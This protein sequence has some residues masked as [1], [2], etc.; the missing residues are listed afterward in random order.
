M[1]NSPSTI[2]H[3][4]AKAVPGAPCDGGMP[5]SIEWLATAQ[6][7][8]GYRVVVVAQGGHAT[9]T[10][11]HYRLDRL[12]GTPLKEAIEASASGQT[13]IHFHATDPETDRATGEDL[14]C[15]GVPFVVTVRGNHRTGAL[16]LANRVYLSAN[17]A[18][19]HGHSVFVY[20]G[21]PVDEYPLGPGKGGYALFLGKVSRRKKGAD[22]A[23]RVAR[24]GQPVVLAGGWHLKYPATWLPFVRSLKVAG[25]VGGE[26]KLHLLQHADALLFP[27][28]WDEPFGLVLIESL[29]VGTPVVA[30]QRG[31]VA[32]LVED[33]ISGIISEPEPEALEQ[34]I[35]K[36][37]TLDRGACRQRVIDHFRIERVAQDYDELYRHALAG[38]RW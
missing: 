4:A 21:L 11:E 3:L 17:H 34:A 2:I 20:N 9:E 14:D 32:E 8:L 29:A 30:T 23:I 37:Q 16:P 27:I 24:R 31:S 7:K 6:S 35:H 1:T 10:F 12:C 25:T 19:R 36:A 38:E 15:L 26:R 28:K 18:T 5:R 33:G 13:I 22:L